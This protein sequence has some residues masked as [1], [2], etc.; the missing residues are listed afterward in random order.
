MAK[1][2]LVPFRGDRKKVGKQR[3]RVSTTRS[4]GPLGRLM[5][6]VPG[7][8]GQAHRVTP[9]NWSWSMREETSCRLR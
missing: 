3:F 7:W 4:L 2:R 5:P 9:S 6:C 1:Y 8:F